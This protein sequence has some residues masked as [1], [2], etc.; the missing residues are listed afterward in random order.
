MQLRHFLSLRDYSSAEFFSI[1]ENAARVK[2]NR[3]ALGAPLQ[4]RHIALLFEKPS[5][6]TRV[7]YEV[8]V[9]QLGGT[10]IV[11]SGNEI[12]IARGESLA[13]TARVLS[14]YV[15]GI[16]IRT[17]SHEKLT[18]L[19]GFS[20]IPVING[21]S[22]KYHPSQ[23]LADFQTILEMGKHP[24][25]I[26]IVYMG[27]GSSNVAHSL[28]FGAALAGSEIVIVSPKEYRPDDDVVEAAQ[29][30]GAKLTISA[31]LKDAKESDV[32]YTDVWV[33]MG[34][35]KDAEAKKT[36]LMPYQLNEKIAS[37][38]NNG[39]ILLHCLPAHKGEEITEAAFESSYSRVFDQAENRLHAQKALMHFLFS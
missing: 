39:G 18:E 29:A 32:L 38:M 30:M 14:R 35:E 28:I 6:R 17:F 33:S 12:Q 19:A 5:T 20:S 10:P 26:R 9:K 13:D 4:D 16:M 25:K 7:S 22:D 8:G 23:T 36:I 37:K 2:R 3:S 1:L 34:Q 21:L 27:D 24:D 15:D 11:L 31:D